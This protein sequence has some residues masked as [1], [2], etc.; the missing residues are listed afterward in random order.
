MIQSDDIKR[1]EIA[2]SNMRRNIIHLAHQAGSNG[3]HIGPALSIVEIMAVLYLQIM[4]IHPTDP[5]WVQRDRFILSK[6]HGAL[7]YYVALYEAGVITKEELYTYEVNGS[8][9][10]GQPSK[11]LQKG[12]EYS[13]G[14]LGLGLS[15]GTGIALA[16]KRRNESFH[17]YVLMGDGELNEGS[18]WESVMFA[19][20]NR[21]SNLTAI[22]D[23]NNMQSDGASDDIIGVDMEALWKG[24]GWEV[25]TC[26][27][28]DV[29][30]LIE[31][32]Q[33]K[34]TDNPKVI[35]AST[36]KGKGI[37]F[38]ENSKD[39]HHNRLADE[40][41]QKALSELTEAGCVTDAN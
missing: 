8:F 30:Q 3:A 24:F 14:S 41:Y 23:R 37:S 29:K 28:H 21:L 33:H 5:A 6:G 27:G 16:A 40:L 2:S 13:S 25:V 7:G 32:F 39:W 12:I 35:I 9:F 15:Y 20:H 10:L 17:T 4:K 31:A 11:K 1:C 18:V 34:D 22:I 19:K 36:V 26:N 38:M